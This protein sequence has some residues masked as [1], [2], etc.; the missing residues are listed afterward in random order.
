MMSKQAK[1]RLRQIVMQWVGEGFTTPPYDDT[2]YE[3]FESL[4]IDNS[5]FPFP[6]YDV[7]RPTTPEEE[8]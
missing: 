4:G 2:T 1:E 8:N 6:S 5:S 3:V 7:E